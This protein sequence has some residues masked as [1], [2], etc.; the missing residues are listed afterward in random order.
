MKKK[1]SPLRSGPAKKRG[2]SPSAR[3]RSR[4]QADKHTKPVGIVFWKDRLI[5]VVQV[6]APESIFDLGLGRIEVRRSI[7]FDEQRRRCTIWPLSKHVH[8]YK[9]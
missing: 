8:L 5:E 7:Y 1:K 2:P 9:S 4:A 3:S 6:A